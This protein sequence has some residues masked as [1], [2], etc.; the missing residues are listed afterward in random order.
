MCA[1][2]SRVVVGRTAVSLVARIKLS[3]TSAAHSDVGLDHRETQLA[4][5]L[6]LEG[7]GTRGHCRY[8]AVS[9]QATALLTE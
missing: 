5:V 6:E 9:A 2:S 3:R 4:K 7:V 1:R 8:A